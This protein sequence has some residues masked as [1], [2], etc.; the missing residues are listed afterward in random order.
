MNSGGKGITASYSGSDATISPY[1]I[2]NGGNINITSTG[3]DGI[4]AN[5]SLTINDGALVVA[6]SDNGM[7]SD[8]A[9]YINGGNIFVKSS[10]NDGMES[11][12]FFTITGGRIVSASQ[13]SNQSGIDCSTRPLTITGGIVL[14]LGETTSVPTSGSTVPALITGSM[15][16]N[17]IV[18][19]ESTS[20]TEALT[21]VPP[22]SYNT[23][24]FAGSKL[25]SNT[26]YSIYNG[27]SVS[28]GKNLYGIYL[29]G[30]YTKGA[31]GSTFSTSSLVTQIGGE[32]NQ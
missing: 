4:K 13:A 10:A 20:G 18:H 16:P 28:N 29:D 8:S 9:V 21:F 14:G 11:D 23:L 1:V 5:G 15:T 7:K 24:L 30:T 3:D 17:Q 19:I 31:K 6:S 2:V 12:G 32:V 25:K 27:G 26:T 22:V